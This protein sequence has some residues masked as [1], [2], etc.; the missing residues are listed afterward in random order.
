MSVRISKHIFQPRTGQEIVHLE[1]DHGHV[2]IVQVG[3]QHP[4]PDA[5]IQEAIR[6]H[7]E[8]EAKITER[9]KRFHPETLERL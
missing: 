7:E 1:D 2:Q 4:D 6:Q 3:I 8:T 5:V 9:K